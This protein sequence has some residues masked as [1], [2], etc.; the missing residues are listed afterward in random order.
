MKKI[1]FFTSLIS[2]LLFAVNLNTASIQDLEK[3]KGIGPKKAKAIIEYR[4]H[5]K[6][7]NADDLKNIKGFNSK[8]ISNIKNNVL[9]KKHIK[10][11]KTSLKEKKNKLNKK[12][13][14]LKRKVNK[15]TITAKNSFKNKKS[16]LNKKNHL[17]NK[18]RLK[19]K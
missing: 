9:T 15:K 18:F 10:N 1:L 3:I 6:I 16:K 5:H 4:K 7:K 8:I 11:K 17:K 19:T 13:H 2:S 14:L 12:K